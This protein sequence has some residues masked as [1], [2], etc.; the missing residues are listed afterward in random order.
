VRLAW[1]TPLDGV[2]GD[3][4]FESA[5]LITALGATHA[6]DVFSEDRAHDFVWTQAR[7]PFDL[8]IYDLASSRA[9]QFIWA[10]PC[11]YPGL[12][13][14]SGDSIR[15]TS[16]ALLVHD[17]RA[18]HQDVRGPAEGNLLGPFILA[19]R[20]VVV[21]DA[22]LARALEQRYPGTH[23]RGAL[24]STPPMDLMP[25]RAEAPRVGTLAGPRAQAVE[26]AVR[27]TAD[28]GLA[29]QFDVYPHADDLVSSADIVV[30][31]PWPP[32][33]G[34]PLDA[35][36]ALSAGR[37]VVVLETET[38]AIVPCL[39]PQTWQPRGATP[40]PRP[41][42][43]SV[44][45][46]DEEHSLML[47]L[48]RLGRDAALRSD[49]GAAGRRWWDANASLPHAVQAWQ[50]LIAEAASVDPTGCAAGWRHGALDGSESARALLAECGA[51][52]DFLTPGVTDSR[53]PGL[54][55]PA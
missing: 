11:H 31:V 14:L 18:R 45:P 15:A 5:T 40:Q 9:H 51:S 23:V 36:R 29:L 22:Y 49:L 34:I 17:R 10:Y 48:A 50:A 39:D 32:P 19:S 7:Q 25:A 6:I 4:G 37:A 28:L 12:L 16:S 30:S 3:D 21:P 13:R 53:G 38:S 8:C 27:R 35:L 42:A 52:V 33:A 24:A 43:V 20:L 55:D 1:F 47:A 41:A 2:S 44:D 54:S 46:R 26:K